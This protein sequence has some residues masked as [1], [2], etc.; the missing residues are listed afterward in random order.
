MRG[1]D[2]HQPEGRSLCGGAHE[3][4]FWLL[5]ATSR[6]LKRGS[7]GAAGAFEV[8]ASRD[9][10]AM[11]GTSVTLRSRARA[12]LSHI[13]Q[14]DRAAAALPRRAIREAPRWRRAGVRISG[15]IP[16]SGRM[17]PSCRDSS[18][19]LPGLKSR[20]TRAA[21][22]RVTTQCALSDGVYKDNRRAAGRGSSRPASR[23][24]KTRPSSTDSGWQSNLRKSMSATDLPARAANKKGATLVAPILF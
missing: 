24:R 4:A 14:Q 1:L 21:N 18:R 7:G 9:H 10:G 3:S 8:P 6:Q 12:S 20:R 11:R 19:I 13:E 2:Q 22:R 23:R 15:Q 17:G 5:Q 16:V